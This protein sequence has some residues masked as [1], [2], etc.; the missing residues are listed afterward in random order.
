MEIFVSQ[1]ILEAA[2]SLLLGAAAGFLYDFFRSVRRM[3]RSR[4]LTFITDL[5]FGLISCAALFLL[6]FAMGGGRQRFYMALL[7]FAGGT[8]Y[9]LTV[10]RFC[11][12]F[13]GTLFRFIALLVSIVTFPA[14][15]F[16]ELL[17]EIAQLLKNSFYFQKKCYRITLKQKRFVK[18][19]GRSLRAKR[20]KTR[21]KD[22]EGDNFEA[23]AGKYYY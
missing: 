21:A 6:G 19:Q 9:F 17:I 1:Q 12:L 5:L 23:E 13:F 22:S 14:V 4:V 11:L 20:K 7:A 10:S 3:R 18:E 16:C 8:L 15:K 2:L